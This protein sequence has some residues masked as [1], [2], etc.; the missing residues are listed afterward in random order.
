MKKED[1][2]QLG[3]ISKLHGIKGLLYIFLDV[4]N[5]EN[6]KKIESV[7]LDIKG[8]LIPFFIEKIELKNNNYAIAKFQDVDSVEAASELVG[9]ELF[10]PLSNLP[11]KTGNHF[12][13]HEVIGFEVIDANH[14]NIGFIE[15]ILDLSYQSIFK[16]KFETKEILLPINNK[17]IKKLD[18]ENK[19]FLVEAPAGLI[20]LYLQL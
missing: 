17:I 8:K 11:V 19:T 16:I 15:D 20:E 14:G 5:P 12:Y 3:Y 1:Y 13:F 18:R 2:F 4:D 6:Y 10:L 9:S 7:F